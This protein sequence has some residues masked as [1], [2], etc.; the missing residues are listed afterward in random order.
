MRKNC[1]NGIKGLADKR[2]VLSPE[3]FD[4]E[5]KDFQK[6]VAGVQREVQKKRIQLDQAYAKALAKVQEKISEI[7]RDMAKKHQFAITF[8][9]SQTLFYA[10][11]LDITKEVLERLNSDL[12]K[13]TLKIEKIKG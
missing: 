8:P 5:R 10:E 6:D 9:A 11:Q 13:V 7:V 2:N 3:A 12:P 1:A 4:K